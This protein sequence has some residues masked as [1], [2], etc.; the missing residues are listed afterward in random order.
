MITQK[1]NQS[2]RYRCLTT[3]YDKRNVTLGKL[4]DTMTKIYFS[5]YENK[6]RYMATQIACRWRGAV[7][8]YDNTK[9]RQGLWC[10]KRQ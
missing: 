4:F 1:E 2:D 9:F 10:K 7:I 5:S 6:A 8:K 3:T